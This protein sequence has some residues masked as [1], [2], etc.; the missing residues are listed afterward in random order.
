MTPAQGAPLHADVA[1]DVA[2][3][4]RPDTMRLREVLALAPGLVLPL[5][6]PVGE[7]L[8]LVVDATVVAVGRVVV[9]EDV[10]ALEV[11]GDGA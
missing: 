2:V 3:R 1:V 8:Q 7:P 9:V 6:H 4:F 10:F 11:T 5:P